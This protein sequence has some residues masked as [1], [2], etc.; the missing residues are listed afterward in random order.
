MGISFHSNYSEKNEM[1]VPVLTCFLYAFAG[2]SL[3]IYFLL[4]LDFNLLVGLCVLMQLH[5]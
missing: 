3:G 5:A 2:V 4:V 1:P